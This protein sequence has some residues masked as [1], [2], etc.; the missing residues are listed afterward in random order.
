MEIQASTL[1]SL[2]IA[3][4]DDKA[5]LIPLVDPAQATDGSITFSVSLKIEEYR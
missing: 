3:L 5:R 4:T 1:T 2:R